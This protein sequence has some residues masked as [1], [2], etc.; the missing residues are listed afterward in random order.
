MHKVNGKVRGNLKNA[1][2]EI[3]RLISITFYAH[4]ISSKSHELAHLSCLF[5]EAFNI[6]GKLTEPLRLY[7][8]TTSTK[9]RL[10]LV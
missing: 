1:T 6:C 3:Y 5:Q 4:A 2:V 8:D 10:Y 7:L 9:V